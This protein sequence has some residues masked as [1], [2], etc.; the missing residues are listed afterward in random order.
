MIACQRVGICGKK[1]CLEMFEIVKDRIVGLCLC[2]DGYYMD[3]NLE[4]QGTNRWFIFWNMNEM[5][6][7][8]D[9]LT[10]LTLFF[11]YMLAY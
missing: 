2:G 10:L 7:I 1:I 3:E 5:S 9:E 6:V 11:K 8:T 4:C